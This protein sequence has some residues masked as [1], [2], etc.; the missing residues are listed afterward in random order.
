MVASSLKSRG[1][2]IEFTDVLPTIRNSKSVIKR[3]VECGFPLLDS[4]SPSF[5][6]IN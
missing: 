3:K 1:I 4:E 2:R 6:A 5:L